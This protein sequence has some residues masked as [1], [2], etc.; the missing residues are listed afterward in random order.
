M[1]CSAGFLLLLELPVDVNVLVVY[2][3][4]RS[5]IKTLRVFHKVLPFDS[6]PVF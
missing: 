5:L 4:M 1:L 6:V 2:S 3:F